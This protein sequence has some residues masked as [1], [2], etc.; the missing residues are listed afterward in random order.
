MFWRSRWP[1]PQDEPESN[2]AA[3]ASARITN[4]QALQVSARPPLPPDLP[5]RVA[6]VVRGCFDAV[7]STHHQ[8]DA[9]DKARRP[10]YVAG[11]R[12]CARSVATTLP[13]MPIIAILDASSAFDPLTPA[14]LKRT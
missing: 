11:P 9:D 7:S 4:R 3:D 2:L 6:A 12:T 5:K 10:W 13:G 14:A 8:L 1:L